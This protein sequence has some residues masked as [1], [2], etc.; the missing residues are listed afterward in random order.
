MHLHV[1][2]HLILNKLVCTLV[3]DDSVWL[4]HSQS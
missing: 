3:V 4:S 2:L 1:I